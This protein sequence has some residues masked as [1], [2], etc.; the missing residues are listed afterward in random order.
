MLLISTHFELIFISSYFI[1]SIFS[2]A[3]EERI[4]VMKEMKEL[5]QRSHTLQATANSDVLMDE[6]E[7]LNEYEEGHSVVSNTG[8]GVQPK[9]KSSHEIV[10]MAYD[11]YTPK[12]IRDGEFGEQLFLN[13]YGSHFHLLT[14]L[15]SFA[16][17]LNLCNSFYR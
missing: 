17:L 3:E 4:R 9:K 13:K 14:K 1:N 12:R 2:P 16:I 6:C 8:L 10:E 11:G 5:L 15:L 7:L